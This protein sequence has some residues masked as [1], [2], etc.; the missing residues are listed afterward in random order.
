M[1]VAIITQYWKESEGGGIKVYATNLVEALRHKGVDVNVLF[2]E[3]F[4]SNEFPIH[5]GRITSYYYFYKRIKEIHPD[6]IHN[7]GTGN[8]LI[9]SLLYK[10]FYKCKLIHTFHTEPDGKLKL[11]DKKIFQ[12]LLNN[13][14]CT[15]FVSKG[16]FEKVV[17]VCDL[18]FSDVEITHGGVTK[19]SVKDDEI[20]EFVEKY[21]LNTSHPVIL[22]QAFTANLIK[23]QGLKIVIQAIKLLKNNHP[24]IKLLVTRNGKYCDDLK[25]YSQ[26][27]GVEDVI[28]TGDVENP[29]VP[30]AVS[31]IFIF[32]WLGKS[33]VGLALLEGMVYGK[34]TIIIDNGYESDV[35]IENVNGIMSKPNSVDMAEKINYLVINDELRNRIGANAKNIVEENF[36]WELCATN[37]INIYVK[38]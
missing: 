34:P 35:I 3:G 18:S 21:Q 36:T 14:D 17:E 19:T 20:E 1:K 16:L 38:Y 15:T 31:D 25:A 33:G 12:F 5:G 11:F 6:V 9:P 23:I 27:L 30:I 26:D 28:F 7:H 22:V 13:C 37:F 8:F 29:F 2:K 32:P 10:L 4:D 24:N